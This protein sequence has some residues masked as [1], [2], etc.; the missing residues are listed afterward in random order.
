MLFIP[1]IGN[2]RHNATMK[3][4]LTGSLTIS[5]VG[6]SVLMVLCGSY[7]AMG[8]AVRNPDG[9]IVGL[10]GALLD[11]TERKQTEDQLAR[12]NRTLQTLYQCNQALVHA[13]DEQELLQSVCRILVKVG[14]LRMAWVGYRELNPEKTIR[15]VAQA[16]Y[17][18][19][20][21]E[22]V[23]ATWADTVRGHGPTGAA[24]RTGRP[25]WTKNIETDS[26]IAPW[27]EEALKRGYRSNISL[28]LMSDGNAFGALDALLEELDAFD[29]RAVSCSRNWRIIS[30]YGVMALRTR[31]ERS[32]AEHAPARGAR[33]TDARSAGNDHGRTDRLDRSRGQPAACRRGCQCQRRLTLACQS[34]AEFRRGAGSD[35]ADRQRRQTS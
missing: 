29:E 34:N 30:A 3:S 18:D 19:G 13:S 1:K 21:V 9:I 10:V 20:Y 14:G 26:S 31:D 17:D 16:G 8:E 12:L 24:I 23:K 7:R 33:R 25:S 6:W 11:I 15:P 27:R 35:I 4:S 28:P 22:S 5:N 32:R 2:M